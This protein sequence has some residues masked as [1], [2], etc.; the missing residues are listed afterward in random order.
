MADVL[1]SLLTTSY[2]LLSICPAPLRI[3]GPDTFRRSHRQPPGG[4]K[5]FN[6]PAQLRSIA[7][8]YR[9]DQIQGQ[10]S[11]HGEVRMQ[12]HIEAMAEVL[13]REINMPRDI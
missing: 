10:I 9:V 13:P 5:A 6:R 11:P 3:D 1:S 7:S 2:Q 4:L 8:A 12:T